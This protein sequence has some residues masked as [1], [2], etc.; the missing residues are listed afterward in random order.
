MQLFQDITYLEQKIKH[1]ILFIVFF[2]DDVLF[3]NM[4]ICQIA[5]GNLGTI[6]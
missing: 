1:V 3:I 6:W 5:A 2:S 4:E